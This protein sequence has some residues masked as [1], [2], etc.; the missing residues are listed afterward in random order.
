MV[1]IMFE[2][3]TVDDLILNIPRVRSAIDRAIS[4][5]EA[6][7]VVSREEADAL[8]DKK[9]EELINARVAVRK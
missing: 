7:R 2:K 8:I 4:D 6:G 5:A 3:Q 9:R 1:M